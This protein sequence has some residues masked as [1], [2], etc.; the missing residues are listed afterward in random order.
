MSILAAEGGRKDR[1]EDSIIGMERKKH[2]GGA[3][4]VFSQ[5]TN[6]NISCPLK[7]YGYL[8]RV[9]RPVL[10]LLITEKLCR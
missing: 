3:C 5:I 2:P 1:I 8:V 6:R 7:S 9:T 10:A 4:P